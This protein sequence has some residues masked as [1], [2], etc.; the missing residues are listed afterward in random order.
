MMQ[1]FTHVDIIDLKQ[2]LKKSTEKTLDINDVNLSYHILEAFGTTEK[3][4]ETANKNDQRAYALL[5][6]L[7]AE[8]RYRLLKTKDVNK[9]FHEMISDAKAFIKNLSTDSCVEIIKRSDHIY[10]SCKL[11]EYFLEYKDLSKEDLAAKL[12]PVLSAYTILVSVSKID[13]IPKILFDI[14]QHYSEL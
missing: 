5:A 2:K 6:V 12:D 9:V 11:D 1:I 4:D 8:R 10:N 14:Y 7:R 13:K 3:Y